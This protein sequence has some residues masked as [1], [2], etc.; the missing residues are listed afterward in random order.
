MKELEEAIKNKP[1][2]MVIHP[3][4]VEF[5]KL[6]DERWKKIEVEFNRFK[7]DVVCIPKSYL[8]HR[9]QNISRTLDH[10]LDNPM[11]SISPRWVSANAI[12]GFIK[13]ELLG[14]AP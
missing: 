3:A 1:V 6:Y 7:K 9:L 5:K 8:I 11:G 4:T 13:K 14:D 2:M 10:C 12:K